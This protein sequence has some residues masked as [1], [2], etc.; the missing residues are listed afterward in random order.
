MNPGSGNYLE[1]MED[2]RLRAKQKDKEEFMGRS[3]FVGD[4]VI[5]TVKELLGNPGGTKG[6]VYEEYDIG[7]GPGVS[8]IFTNGS[9]DGFSPE[10]QEKMVMRIGHCSECED[11]AFKNVSV[12][13][14]D[15]ELGF[16]KPAFV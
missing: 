16:F 14:K 7:Y 8:I 10:D 4:V 15:F 11:Y 6:V 5:S 1:D 9:Y 2:Q 3:L 13:S 12:L